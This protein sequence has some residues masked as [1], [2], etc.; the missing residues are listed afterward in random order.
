MCEKSSTIRVTATDVSNEKS[1]PLSAD[2]LQNRCKMSSCEDHH[3]LDPDL[4]DFAMASPDIP[5][6]PLAA[7][8]QTEYSDNLLD[9]ELPAL[10]QK[11]QTAK[12]NRIMNSVNN[13]TVDVED[14]LISLDDEIAT[15]SKPNNGHSTLQRSSS[16]IL[17]DL[18]HR[19]EDRKLNRSVSC[20]NLEA[21]II[22][23]ELDEVLNAS[24]TE[25]RYG[26]DVVPDAE[27]IDEGV[28]EDEIKQCLMELDNYL[29]GIVIGDDSFKDIEDF[30]CQNNEDVSPGCSKDVSFKIQYY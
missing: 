1:S 3:R 2:P 20:D 10:E 18:C 22:L 27:V 5:K 6:S 7:A 30:D 4:I 25:E 11:L 13:T 28:D 29:E 14:I 16:E 19:I 24:L 17:L 23:K 26:E 9:S 21:M 12:D 8:L 15:V